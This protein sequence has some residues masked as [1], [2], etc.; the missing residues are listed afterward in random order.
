MQK[1]WR[2]DEGK[3][4]EKCRR[5]GEKV[6]KHRCHPERS[7]K[8]REANRAAESKDPYALIDRR[9]PRF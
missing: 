1:Q 2:N 9:A 8:I 5:S 3:M 4:E 7:S 6:Q